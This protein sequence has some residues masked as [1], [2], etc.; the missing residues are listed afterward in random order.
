V[1]VLKHHVDGSQ[2]QLFGG[3]GDVHVGQRRG[4]WLLQ[5][6]RA[7]RREQLDGDLRVIPWWRSDGYEVRLLIE[8]LTA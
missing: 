2:A 7:A 3:G 6:H 1:T 4:R 8:E 5:Q